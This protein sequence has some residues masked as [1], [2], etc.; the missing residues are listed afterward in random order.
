[1]AKETLA[2][3]IAKKTFNS[4]DFQKSWAV[5]MDA[6]GP[7]LEPAFS[8]NYQARIHLTAALN[9]IS[10][11]DIKGGMDKL[12]EL[13]KHLET[14]TD[15]AAWLFFMGLCFEM[16]GE[17]DQMLTCYQQA[18]EYNHRFYLPYLKVAKSAHNDA[19]FDVAEENYHAAIQ[20]FDETGLDSQNRIIL[21][22]IYTNLTSCLTMMHYY[23]EAETALNTAVQLLPQQPGRSATAAILYAAMG[24][25]E[26]AEHFLEQTSEQT[27]VM[28]ASTQ[29]FADEILSGIHPHFFCTETD[30][31]CINEFLDWFVDNH[32]ILAE[33]LN[34][35]EYDD[36]FTLLQ[37][38]LEPL[39]PF[40][41]R[42]PEIGIVPKE[43]GYQITFADFY[44]VSLAQGYADLIHAC[45]VE[46]AN[47]WEFDIAH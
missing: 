34:K 7:I 45:P 33:K 29:K 37:I 9:R 44:M 38:Q 40:L 31:D 36:V 47:C 21:A 30:E 43:S 11:R 46:L 22:S 1:M 19:V 13:Q 25:K 39:F 42:A 27:P 28:S 3:K 32:D 16:A 26:K 8:E 6:F 20:C 41:K 35:Q 5:H 10:R 12:K 24:D 23:E 18:S 15:K 2:E 4:A 17:K 14:D